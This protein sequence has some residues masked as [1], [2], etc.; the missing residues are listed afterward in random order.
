MNILL[1]TRVYVY[2][3]VTWYFHF[4]ISSPFNYPLNPD[5]D[6]GLEVAAVCNKLV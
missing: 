6:T 3:Y 1:A 4:V 2:V 5:M